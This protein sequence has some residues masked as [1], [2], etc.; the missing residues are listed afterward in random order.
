MTMAKKTEKKTSA[1]PNSG[2]P[3]LVES[4]NDKE[5]HNDGYKDHLQ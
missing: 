3:H 1:S 5:G 2:D 4:S